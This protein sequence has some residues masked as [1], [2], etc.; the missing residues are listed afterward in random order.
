MEMIVAM[1]ILTN[2]LKR[3]VQESLCGVMAEKQPHYNYDIAGSA[4]F[5]NYFRRTCSFRVHWNAT[6]GAQFTLL[7]SHDDKKQKSVT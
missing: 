1:N 2:L 3:M 4:P 5:S 6:R 7:S